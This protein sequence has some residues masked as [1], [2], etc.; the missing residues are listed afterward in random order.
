MRDEVMELIIE[1]WAFRI[2][3]T[4]N[5]WSIDDDWRLI[6]SNPNHIMLRSYLKIFSNEIIDEYF[7]D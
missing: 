5:L 2:G 7:K 6:E 4:L 3:A 1:K